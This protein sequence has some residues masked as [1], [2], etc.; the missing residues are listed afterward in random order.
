MQGTVVAG[1][2]IGALQAEAAV[3]PSGA[4]RYTHFRRAADDNIAFQ[5]CHADLLLRQGRENAR[6]EV[7]TSA[8]VSRCL[9]LSVRTPGR[10]LHCQCVEA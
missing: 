4:R 3:L 7:V 10:G 8:L 5:M 6:H 1:V 2:I 9:V